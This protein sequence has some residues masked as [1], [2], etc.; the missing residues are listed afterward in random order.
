MTVLMHSLTIEGLALA[1]AMATVCRLTKLN[2]RD[3]KLSWIVVYFGFFCGAMAAMYEAFVDGPTW[4]A[5]VLLSSLALFLWAS[6]H[7]WREHAP[8]YLN[9]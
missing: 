5:L 4:T 3:H 9:R 8:R 2:I 7:S 6:R 1:V